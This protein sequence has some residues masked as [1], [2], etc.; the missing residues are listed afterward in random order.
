MGYGATE[1]VQ[2]I[3][4]VYNTTAQQTANAL[5]SAGYAGEQIASSI[6]GTYDISKAGVE[7]TIQSAGIGLDTAVTTVGTGLTAGATT[8]GSWISGLFRV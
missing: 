6:K 8:V 5:K 7:Q 3:A 1:A 2:G 4:R